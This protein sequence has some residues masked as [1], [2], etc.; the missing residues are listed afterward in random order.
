LTKFLG[1]LSNFFCLIASK[2]FPEW[3]IFPVAKIKDPS[4][5]KDYRHISILPALS[6]ALD[7]CVYLESLV[8]PKND[9]S[10]EIQR[11][12]RLQIDISS[13]AI[14]VR[15]SRPTKFILYKTLIRLVLL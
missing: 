13:Q 8:T 4:R 12:F 15:A 5:L 10:L 3:K 7:E 6:K 11:D 1:N 14:A 2:T 9:V